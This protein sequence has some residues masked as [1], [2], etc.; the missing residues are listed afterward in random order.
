MEE[1]LANHLREL[2]GLS[3]NTPHRAFQ[4]PRIPPGTTHPMFKIFE[5][6]I[7]SKLISESE[8]MTKKLQGFQRMYQNYAKGLFEMN[9]TGIIPPGHPLYNRQNSIETLKG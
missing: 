6:P 8:S 7:K 1:S 4:F 3:P 5:N 2:Y 9:S